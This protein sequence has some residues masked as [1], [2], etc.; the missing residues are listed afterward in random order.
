MALSIGELVGY[1]DLDTSKAEA[2]ADSVAG[3]FEGMGG[4]WG[5]ILGGAGL[6]AGGLFGASL[7]GAMGDEVSLDKLTASLGLSESESERIGGVAGDLYANAYGESLDDVSTA[8]GQ[9]MKNIDGMAAASSSDLQSVTAGVMDLA[10]AFDQDLGMTTAAVGQM[11]RTGMAKDATEALDMLTKGLQGPANK[12]DDLLETMNEYGTQFRKLGLDGKDAMGLLSQGLQG[13]ARDADIVADS[14]KEFSIRSQEAATVS[15]IVDGQSVL[16]LNEL[17]TA[18]ESVGVQILN[19][20]GNLTAAGIAF[21]EDL[22]G[23]GV[24]A[25][26]ALDTVLDGLKGISDPLARNRSAIALFGTQAEDMGDALLSLDLDSAA[27]EVGKVGGAAA[28]MGADLNDNAKTNLA[29]FGRSLRQN[30]VELVGGSVLPVVTD[31]TGEL[32]K[33]VGPAFETAGDAAKTAADFLSDHKGVAVGLAV[34]IGTLAAVTAAHGAVMAV[35]AAGGMTAWLAG[36]KLISAATKVWAAVQWAMNAAMAANPIVLVALAVVA[37]IAVIVLIATKTDWFQKLWDKAW[38]A[39]TDAA[40]KAFG[41]VKSNWPLILAIL[42]G[43]I[44]LAVLAIAKNWDK[45]KDGAGAV[46]DWI[47]D[48]FGSLVGFFADLPGKL[49]GGL[50]SLTEKVR[51]AFSTAME[52]GKEKVLTIGATIKEWLAGLPGKI[53][54]LGGKFADAGRGLLQ[55]FIDGMKNAAG[56]IEGIA[57][58]VWDTVKGLLNGAITKINAALEFTIK[59]PGKDLSINLPDIPQLATGGR[60]TASTL[61][62]IGEGQEPESVLPDSVLRGLL[63]RAHTAGRESTRHGGG[64]TW[65]V[66]GAPGMDENLLAEKAWYKT[67]TRG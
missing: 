25:R 43:P 57:G 53:A 32:A 56:V 5:A 1:V 9:V 44:G 41:W 36:T 30:V 65:N 55:G 38:G 3:M 49:A 23:G 46:K 50:S 47:T 10:T 16:D 24:K 52:A 54:E 21:Q 59:L 62:V 17:G 37:L 7:S 64:D 28:K 4:K 2:A 67:R 27:N 58:N 33:G 29:A 22:A 31:L 39:I 18:L 51:D 14:L 11:I 35:A 48:K 8:V 13:G 12:A 15:K 61:A 42:T 20:K 40:S 34:V 66:Y 45:I 63:E 60:A 26:Q 19:N 6:A